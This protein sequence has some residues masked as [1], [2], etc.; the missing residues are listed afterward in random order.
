[1]KRATVD[2]LTLIDPETASQRRN[3]ITSTIIHRGCIGFGILVI[4]LHFVWSHT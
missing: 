1:M 4:I 3:R 2:G